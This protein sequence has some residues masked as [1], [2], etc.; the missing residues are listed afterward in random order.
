MGFKKKPLIGQNIKKVFA[1]NSETRRAF[2]QA[3]HGKTFTAVLPLNGLLFET[4]FTPWIDGSGKKR[5]A[6]GFSID[7]TQ[8]FKS[9]Q[10]LWKKEKREEILIQSSRDLVTFF[11]KEGRRLYE[12]PEGEKIIGF[13]PGERATVGPFDHIH[14]GDVKSAK[15]AYRRALAYPAVPVRVAVRV[16]HKDGH[17]LHGDVILTNYLDVP[18][19]EAVVAQTRDVTDQKNAEEALRLSEQRLRGLIENSQDLITVL[20]REGHRIYESPSIRRILGFEPGERRGKTWDNHPPEDV[21]KARAVVGKAL[22]NPWKAIP[23]LLKVRRKDGSYIDAEMTI[24]NLL[25]DPAVKGIVVNS[26]DVTLRKKAEEE[27]LGQERRFRALIEG[28]HDVI[29]L[30]DVEGKIIYVSPSVQKVLGYDPAELTGKIGWEWIHPEDLP[31]M[32]KLYMGMVKTPGET[33]SSEIRLRHRSGNW[34]PIEIT[35]TN[36]LDNPNINAVVANYRDNSG[37]KAADE[38]LRKRESY[39]RALIENSQDVVAI[40][41]THGQSTYISPSYERIVGYRIADRL[42]RS[43]FEIIHPE[44]QPLIRASYEELIHNPS[45]TFNGNFRLKKATGEW[46]YFE[47]SATNHLE[48]PLVNGIILNFRDVTDKK[49]A[50]E[51][52]AKSEEYYRSLIEKSYDSYIILNENGSLR[53]LSPSIQRVLGFSV[54]ERIGKSFAERIHPED[55]EKVDRL[56]KQML[57]REITTTLVEYRVQHKDGQWL[58]MEGT[59]NRLLDNPA[60]KGIVVNAREVTERKNMED[61]LRQSEE[62]FRTLMDKLPGPMVLHDGERNLYVNEAFLKLLGYENAEELIGRSPLLDVHPEER[63]EVAKR[64]RNLQKPEVINPPAVRRFLRKNG[65][66]VWTQTVSMS[67]LFQGKKVAVALL[68]DLTEQINAESALRNSEEKFRGLIE[69]SHDIITL[70]SPEG[71]N[72]Y[73]SPSV[74]T[75]MGYR[76]DERVGKLFFEIV[77]PDDRALLAGQLKELIRTKGA[78]LYSRARILHKDGNWRHVEGTGTNLLHNPAIGGI[79]LNYRDV[80]ERFQA[81]EALRKSEDYFRSLIEN[82]YEVMI[83]LSREGK[84]R[85]I[86]PSIHRVLGFEPNERIG[87]DFRDRIHPDDLKRLNEEFKTLINKT[88]PSSVTRMRLKH[89]N[90]SWKYIEGSGFNLLDHPSVGG[91]V[92]NYRDVTERVMAE[93]ELRKSE[94][95]F[96]NLIERS[97]DAMMIHTQEMALY[98]NPAFLKLL[99]YDRPEELAGEFWS[100]V[101]P[102]GEK[103]NVKNRIRSLGDV[104]TVNPP[105]E[106]MILRKDGTAIPT[107]VISFGILFEGQ[108]AVAAVFR[109]L[110][111][112]KNAEQ[113]MMKYARLGAIGEMAAGLAHEIR[114]P[115]SGIGLSA[116]YLKR[117]LKEQ[118]DAEIQVQNILDQGERLKQLVNDTLDFSR[119][120]TSQEIERVDVRD[121]METS[122]R[123]VQ[124]QFGPRQSRVQVRWNFEKDRYFVWVNPNRIR[125]VLVNLILN[126]YQ[127]MDQGGILTLDCEDDGFRI[128]L[129]VEDSGPGIP[130]EAQS[131]LFEPFFTTKKSG[132]GLGLSVSK[133]IAETYGGALRVESSVGR[134]AFL[135]E[136]PAG[137]GHNELPSE[138]PII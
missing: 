22:K 95:S 30:F 105:I 130:A 41:N 24:T 89:K 133:R 94:E 82:S 33:T 86:S 81:E 84:I 5:G 72:L 109:D 117:K 100:K 123:F 47:A 51:D 115:L 112:R 61:A 125:Q 21:P 36:L 78:A 38:A 35:L 128:V 67:L 131:R 75:I 108:L 43:F 11:S 101:V 29:N 74:E 85:Y 96:R 8:S 68:H 1:G 93:E 6:L 25:G 135:V 124:V 27:L 17:W 57:K 134:T 118:P 23:A 58:Y 39:F 66:E 79:V 90:G 56:F 114:N 80:T 16:R 70:I 65:S 31:D 97:P 122:L 50:E 103:E 62:S 77:H 55:R 138:G 92:F 73:V 116:Q 49:K 32:R 104:S 120:T 7:V 42:G 121:L 83:L 119:D 48:N 12:S 13:K 54:E 59:A 63:E 98:V 107:E 9:L 3:L 127:A 87:V 4:R 18:G 44:D 45:V 20:D 53:Y 102:P 136:L 28:T 64:I 106:R 71:A 110:R 34:I 26:R 129:R 99:G 46:R 76:P 88:N 10:E 37:K 40:V 111:E 52:L 19:V 113:I 69:N 132:S 137:Q 15:A 91:L 2:L 60:V 14:P 126:A